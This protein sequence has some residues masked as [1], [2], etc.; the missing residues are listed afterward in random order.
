MRRGA[1][2]KTYS[3]SVF[4]LPQGCQVP[5]AATCHGCQPEGLKFLPWAEIGEI[6]GGGVEEEL[7]T[8]P[9]KAAHPLPSLTTSSPPIGQFPRPVDWQI[10]SKEEAKNYERPQG[11]SSTE[12][13]A[14]APSPS[15]GTPLMVRWEAAEPKMLCSGSSRCPLFGP[16]KHR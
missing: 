14:Q 16:R 7:K 1:G 15:A 8:A 6:K 10:D 2:N 12:G 3:P 4:S 11:L 5:Q 9:V 13:R